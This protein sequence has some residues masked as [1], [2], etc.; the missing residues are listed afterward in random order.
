MK[1]ICKNKKALH[2]YEILDTYEAGI[3]LLGCEV[4]SCR[5]G[6]ANLVDGYAR[7]KNS[8]VFLFNVHISKYIFSNQEIHD[9]LRV[10][11]LLLHK[12]EIKRL[13]GKVKEKGLTLIP[14]KMYI[15]DNKIKV[16]L[17][18][19]KGRKLYDKRE[20]IKKRD[21]KR[22]ASRELKEKYKI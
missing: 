12:K 4:K 8:E 22:L 14:L 10:R 1:L 16:E 18:L 5:I 7:I 6:K 9:P 21:E 19:A 2:N 3:S 20:V 13:T 11:K 17:G 15:K